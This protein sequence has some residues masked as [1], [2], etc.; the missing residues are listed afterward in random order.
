MQLPGRQ[1][2]FLK[3]LAKTQTPIVLV[4]QN[5][6]PLSLTWEQEHVPAILECWYPGDKGG[7]AVAEVL[8]GKTA[9]S[10]RLPMSF[11]KSVGQVPCNYNRMP[12]GGRR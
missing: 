8:F 12:G 10:G 6:R 2:D 5:G 3:E 4:L 9:P 11:P 1:L 7:R